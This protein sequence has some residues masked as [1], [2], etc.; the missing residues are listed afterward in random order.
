M[1][2]GHLVGR[3][4]LLLGLAVGLLGAAAG[5]GSGSNSGAAS[6]PKK[7]LEHKQTTEDYMKNMM[8]GKRPKGGGAPQK[9]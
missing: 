5:C 1:G 3:R 9:P 8:K 7:D 2:D 6:E 4:G